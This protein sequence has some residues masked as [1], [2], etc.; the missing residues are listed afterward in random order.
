MLDMSFFQ[1]PVSHSI[2]L[3]SLLATC[4]YFSPIAL[5]ESENS[6]D[7]D[8]AAEAGYIDNFLYQTSNE[9]STA[10]YKLSSQ[11][12]LVVEG[13]KSAFELDAKVDSYIFSDFKDDDHNEFKLKP[14]YQYMLA[15]N[16]R[17][18]VSGHWFNSYIYRGTGLS[19]GELGNLEAGDKKENFGASIGFEYGNFDSRGRL[20]FEVS[21]DEGE[22]TTRRTETTELDSDTLFMKSSFDYLLSG[23]TYMTFD[24]DYQIDDYPNAPARNRDSLTALAGV[25]WQTTVISE[26]SF[27][28]GYQNLKFEDSLL[29][30]DAFKWRF[31]Y[32][33]QPSDF[34]TIQLVSNRKF[35]K[36]DRIA[37]TYSLAEIYQIDI[38]HAFTDHISVS[39]KVSFN[40]EKIVTLGS[41]RK[42]SYLSSTIGVNY[43]RTERLGFYLNYKTKSLDADYGDIDYRYNNVS[44]GLKVQL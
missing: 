41:R 19:L 12:A 20:N 28:V 17:L 7:F 8:V 14:T 1:Y 44:L 9:K 21:Y 18:Y 15:Q 4:S 42:E 34:T 2:F 32:T 6:L 27:L 13:Q 30:D 33:W 5:A 40:N 35:D 3:S 22:F 11:M 37:S 16:Q 31:D 25:K 39:A 23:K 36:T 26:L 29:D 24:V 43:Q 10:F 38:S